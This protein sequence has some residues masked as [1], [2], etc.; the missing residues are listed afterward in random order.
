MYA[1]L[2]SGYNHD[3]FYWGFSSNKLCQSL[4]VT[5]YSYEVINCKILLIM[6]YAA[7]CYHAML[8]N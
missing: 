7:S 6:Y 2:V 5:E 3:N 4:V 1:R 8:F